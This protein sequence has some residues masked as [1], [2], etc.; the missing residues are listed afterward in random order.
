MVGTSCD[1]LGIGT[2]QDF[3]RTL[4][5]ETIRRTSHTGHSDCAMPSSHVDHPPHAQPVSL[6]SPV[7]T[8]LS[9]HLTGHS[10]T[11]T[12]QRNAY[13][14]GLWYVSRGRARDR[15]SQPPTSSGR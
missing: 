8:L 3:L 7:H 10:R 14:A 2:Q 11:R 6:S 5:Q 4:S 15:S 12:R 1:T 9:L 13:G